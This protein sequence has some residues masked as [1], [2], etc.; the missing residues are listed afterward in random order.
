MVAIPNQQFRQ[1]DPGRAQTPQAIETFLYLG[2]CSGG[3]CNAI[4]SFN[5]LNVA[6]DELDQGELAEVVTGHLAESGGPVLAMRLFADVAGIIGSVTKHPA[7]SSTGTIAVTVTP[8]TATAAIQ[9][10]DPTGTPVY[11][12]LTTDLADAGASDVDIFPST[13]ATGD[14][15]AIGFTSP[16]SKLAIVT[17]TVG[18]VG[19]VTYKYWNGTAWTAVSGMTDTTSGLTVSPGTVVWTMP[20]DWARKSINGSAELYFIVIECATTYTINPLVTSATIE[21]VGPHDTYISELT[22]VDSG[23]VAT[24]TFSYTLDDG[25][26]TT[27]S[28]ITIPSGGVYDIPN[29]GL[30]VTFTPGGGPSYFA[31][32]DSF[33]FTTTAPFYSTTSLAAAFTKIGLGSDQFAAVIPV[34]RPASGSTAATM[35]A[36]LGVHLDT[37]ATAN[38]WVG[39]MMDA[40]VDTEANVKTAFASTSHTRVMPCFTESSTESADKHH[41]TSAKP[42]NG[43]GAPR[44][45]ILHVVGP[46]AG[47][48]LI[49]THLGRFAS[50]PLTRVRAIGYNEEKG[51][52]A[53]SAAQFCTLRTWEGFPGGFYINRP[54]I[55]SP[56]GSDYDMW[57]YRRI[58]DTAHSTSH[59]ALQRFANSKIRV[60]T[61]GVNAGKIN[62][63][64]A[65]RIEGEIDAA[66]GENLTVPLDAEGNRG[67]VAFVKYVVDREHDVADSNRVK[68]AV[69]MVRD[70]Y[71]E[72]LV[73][74]IGFAA[75]A[76]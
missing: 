64:E 55:K 29:T 48:E 4:S 62:E 58:A 56:A 60:R 13:E 46:R 59:R 57:Q 40:G 7:G 47:S 38:R 76:V 17:G 32:G 37:L 18:T 71:A 52:A 14:Q 9:I 41:A 34:G 72:E 5:D 67:H 8:Q 23:T 50:G 10:D 11:T 31:A 61:D 70:G 45:S 28:P 27:P 73:T 35:F 24:G 42:F 51:T 21:N 53:M 75:Q 15:F 39:S 65:L 16:F 25:Y 1:R 68:G 2:T 66:L 49:S 44:K 36:S 69:V 6:A 22:I 19:T 63:K 43:W 26:T 30:R 54:N 12:D 74:D 20:T 33:T 3:E